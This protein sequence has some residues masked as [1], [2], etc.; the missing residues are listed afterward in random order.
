MLA[1]SGGKDS[2]L[3]VHLFKDEFGILNISPDLIPPECKGLIDLAHINA[4]L[5]VRG[6]KALSI[7]EGLHLSRIPRKL[8][9]Q[10]MAEQDLLKRP[11]I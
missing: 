2:V 9:F 3:M 11:K 10:T 1:V 8:Q 4:R 7:E 6:F 5:V